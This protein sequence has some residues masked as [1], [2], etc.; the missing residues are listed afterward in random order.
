MHALACCRNRRP[1]PLLALLFV[2]G[3]VASSQNGVVGS[4]V[5]SGE[6]STSMICI[7]GAFMLFTCSHTL[8]HTTHK[9][10]RR[11]IEALHSTIPRQRI[12]PWTTLAEFNS[13]RKA[14]YAMPCCAGINWFRAENPKGKLATPKA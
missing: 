1:P 5:G 6:L 12:V 4:L 3:V 14:R 10:G 8:L 9:I 11:I 2:S 13:T 7:T